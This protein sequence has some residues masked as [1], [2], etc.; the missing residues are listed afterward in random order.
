MARRTLAILVFFLVPVAAQAAGSP[1]VT[2][3]DYMTSDWAVEDGAG[4]VFPLKNDSDPDGDL[5]SNSISIVV[6]PSHGTGSIEFNGDSPPKLNFTPNAGYAGPD[7]IVYRVCDFG[8]NCSTGQVPINVIGTST[9]TVPVTTT[10]VPVTTTTVPVTTTTVPVTTTTV[11]VT[12]T[13][14]PVTT[15]APATSPV[16]TSPRIE[17]PPAGGAT[18]ETLMGLVTE[19]GAAM[20]TEA[21]P[22]RLEPASRGLFPSIASIDL[23]SFGAV[24]VAP[25]ALPVVGLS[26]ASALSLLTGLRSPVR[27]LRRGK[28]WPVVVDVWYPE[29]G[30]GIASFKG[31]D[32][33]V[34]AAAVWRCETEPSAHDEMWVRAVPGDDLWVATYAAPRLRRKG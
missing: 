19:H 14:V 21:V 13:T 8:G 23:R 32:R 34:V 26:M 10:T 28:K 29:D 7:L 4:R 6:A 3:P 17:T 25:I 11:P 31:G 12:T 9:T 15:T 16:V 27:R 30:F 22:P 5:D 24:A 20:D 1:P 18:S 2:Q 33:V